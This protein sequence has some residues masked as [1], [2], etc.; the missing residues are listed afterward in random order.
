MKLFKIAGFL[1]LGAAAFAQDVH[2]DYD[3]GANFTAYHT[4]Q[5]VNA[6]A[7]QAADQLM[8]Q[9]IKR[10]V[11]EQLVAKGLQ[12]VEQGGDLQIAYQ[13]ALNREKQFNGFTSGPRWSGFGQ[14][15]TSTVE[16][17]KLVVD[18]YDPA[19]HQL[20]WRGDAEKTLDI[21]KDPDKNY[22]NLQKAMTKLFKNYPPGIG[23]N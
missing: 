19:K 14:V 12:R 21:K 3:R 5:W 7:G 15:D 23:Q 11:D 6:K 8:D 2:F 4:Y 20:V 10:S 17:G 1:C 18:M 13:T 22:R 16:I 9:N